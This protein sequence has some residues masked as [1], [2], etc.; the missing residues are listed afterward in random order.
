MLN[1]NVINAYSYI[2]FKVLSLL[3]IL[4]NEYYLKNKKK[5]LHYLILKK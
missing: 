4:K 2:F 5:N 1:L 3:N